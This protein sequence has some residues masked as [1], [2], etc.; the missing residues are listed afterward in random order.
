MP[1]AT[2][3]RPTVIPFKLRYIRRCCVRDFNRRLNN[4]LN[5]LHIA[6]SCIHNVYTH[7]IAC[8]VDIA[9][10]T[11]QNGETTTD[12]VVI[13]A[14]VLLSSLTVADAPRRSS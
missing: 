13:F 7:N 2:T 9:Y 1:T 10:R 14:I 6:G 12:A 8:G 11:H 4:R 3:E 5:G